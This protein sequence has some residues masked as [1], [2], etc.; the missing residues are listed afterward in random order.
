MN[1][2]D[3]DP[4]IAGHEWRRDHDHTD[5]ERVADRYENTIYGGHP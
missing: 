3:D 5:E 4:R 2:P 1:H